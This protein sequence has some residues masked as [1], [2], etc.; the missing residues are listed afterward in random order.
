MSEQKIMI[1][2]AA[3]LVDVESHVLRYWEEE[4]HIPVSRTEMGHRYYTKENLQLFCC[5]KKLKDEGVTIK[6][7]KL[8]VPDLLAVQKKNGQAPKP[9]RH[10][11]EAKAP[12]LPA[13]PKAKPCETT[14]AEVVSDLPLQQVRELIGTVLTDVVTSNNEVLKKEISRSV[15]SEVLREMHVLMQ[16]K[17]QHDEEHFR[18]LDLLIRQ[19]QA[20]RKEASASGT[21]TGKIRRIFT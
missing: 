6:E 11:E 1:S 3:K 20:L 2:E 17:E 5:I 10:E 13:S 8:L 18:K 4:L 14:S 15:S 21:A 12:S 7:L 19:Q 16:T 9:K